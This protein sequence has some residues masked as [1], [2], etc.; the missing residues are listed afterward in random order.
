MEPCVAFQ[1]T[2]LSVTV[3]WTEAVNWSVPPAG[4]DSDAGERVTAVTLA[5]GVVGRESGVCD[6]LAMPLHPEIKNG[7]ADKAR[8]SERRACTFD[9]KEFNVGFFLF[10]DFVLTAQFGYAGMPT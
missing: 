5:A 2:D 9:C 7:M 3:P 10:L 6:A 4:I 8:T 1:A